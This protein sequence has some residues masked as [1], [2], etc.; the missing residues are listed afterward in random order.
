MRVASTGRSR[1]AIAR[2]DL[3]AILIR[4]RRSPRSTGPAAVVSSTVSTTAAVVIVSERKW[5]RNG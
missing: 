5:S 4:A 2:C 1:L 3:S